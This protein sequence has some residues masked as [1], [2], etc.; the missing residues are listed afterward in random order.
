[1]NVIHVHRDSASLAFH[2][3]VPDPLFAPFSPLIR[4]LSSA[5]YGQPGDEVIEHCRTLQFAKGGP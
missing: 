2:M 5:V 4:L 1:M 3:D